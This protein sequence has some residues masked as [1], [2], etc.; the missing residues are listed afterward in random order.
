M[1]TRVIEIC[2]VAPSPPPA[3]DFTLPL[4]F[5]DTFCLKFL[6]VEQIFFYRFPSSATS[7]IDVIIPRLKRSLSLALR[8]FLPIAGKLTWPEEAEIPFV[9][10]K[11]NDTVSL[12]IAESTVDSFDLL[13]GDGPHSELR[14]VLSMISSSKDRFYPS[15]VN[16]S[17]RPRPELFPQ[18]RQFQ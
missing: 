7:P 9:L 2:H 12:T 1:T 5:F 18:I 16:L 6:P 15:I 11:Q 13:S 17:C 14:D 10:Y 4:T 8:H 3:A